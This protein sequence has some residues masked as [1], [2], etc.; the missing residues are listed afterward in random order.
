[1]SIC[2][3]LSWRKGANHT[4]FRE[5]SKTNSDLVVIRGCSTTGPL[6]RGMR[7]ARLALPWCPERVGAERKGLW[8]VAKVLMSGQPQ[9]PTLRLAKYLLNLVYM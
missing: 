5:P 1:M 6:K 3:D 4:S 7:H 9:G 8:D 2:G